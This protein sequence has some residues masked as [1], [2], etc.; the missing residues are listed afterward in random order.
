M[1]E[2]TFDQE[3]CLTEAFNREDIRTQV[4]GEMAALEDLKC[5]VH[6]GGSLSLLQPEAQ[7]LRPE[8]GTSLPQIPPAPRTGWV[9]LNTCCGNHWVGP[10]TPF[11]Q[12]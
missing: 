7:M 1:E 8:E 11:T 2:V 4:R 10:P 12:S 3:H 5:P 9:L 6:C